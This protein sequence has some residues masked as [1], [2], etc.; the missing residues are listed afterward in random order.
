MARRSSST[1]R[2]PSQAAGVAGRR[3]AGR[4]GA[5]V[6][7]QR[8]VAATRERLTCPRSSGMRVIWLPSVASIRRR[9][10]IRIEVQR[11]APPTPSASSARSAFGPSWMPAPISASRPARS[12]MRRGGK[13]GAARGG[14]R[15]SERRSGGNGRSAGGEDARLRR[16][17]FAYQVL[18]RKRVGERI[19]I[20]GDNPV[21]TR[22]AVTLAMPAGPSRRPVAAPRGSRR[23]PRAPTC[24]PAPS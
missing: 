9:L 5:T 18:K 6:S 13:A 10:S 20:H 19:Q 17:D 12:S 2:I 14:C 3:G 15:H 21:R 16:R 24:P 7:A 1:W 23:R 22:P 11:A 8:A 4:V